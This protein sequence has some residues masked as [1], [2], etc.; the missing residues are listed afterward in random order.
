MRVANEVAGMASKVAEI[1]REVTEA[2]GE[3]AKV[4]EAGCGTVMAVDQAINRVLGALSKASNDHSGNV[5]EAIEPLTKSG[6]AL[7]WY[8]PKVAEAR[9]LIVSSIKISNRETSHLMLAKYIPPKY[10]RELLQEG[11]LDSIQQFV[12]AMMVVSLLSLE[13]SYFLKNFA[14]SLISNFSTE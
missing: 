2:I 6:K 7:R 9:R 3:L 12:H 14:R 8:H 11:I 4:V 1:P 13:L 5:E 10:N